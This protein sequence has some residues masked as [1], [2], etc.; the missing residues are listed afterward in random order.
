[1][2]E[3]QSV[4]NQSQKLESEESGPLERGRRVTGLLMKGKDK[5]GVKYYENMFLYFIFGYDFANHIIVPMSGV[6]V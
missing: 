4:Y 2:S 6:M 3:I 5:K 1:M